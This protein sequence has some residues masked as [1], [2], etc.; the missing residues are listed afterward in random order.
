MPPINALL[1][2]LKDGFREHLFSNVGVLGKV[3]PLSTLS[4]DCLCLVSVPSLL[5]IWSPFGDDATIDAI[6]LLG[7]PFAV[8]EVVSGIDGGGII[9]ADWWCLILDRIPREL[10]GLSL[11]ANKFAVD[12][13]VLAGTSFCTELS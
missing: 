2:N 10:L 9:D 7:V 4:L 5:S 6:P 1:L 8:K 3:N 11:G 12:A 13:E